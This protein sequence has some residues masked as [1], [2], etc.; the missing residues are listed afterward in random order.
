MHSG[1]QK[2]QTKMRVIYRGRQKKLSWTVDGR[3]SDRRAFRKER[4]QNII[5][6]K[7][8]WSAL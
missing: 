1:D 2:G 7:E 6:N 4:S 5:K 3:K 8:R